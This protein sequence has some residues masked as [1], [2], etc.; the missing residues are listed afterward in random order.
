MI[1]KCLR[2]SMRILNPV[3]YKKAF[4]L[5]AGVVLILS[6]TGAAAAPDKTATA[7]TECL[8]FIKSKQYDNAI[9]VCT[10]VIETNPSSYQAFYAR[11][12]AYKQMRRYGVA[13]A[14]YTN[15]IKIDPLFADAYEARGNAYD[16]KGAHSLALADYSKAIELNPSSY[17]VFHNRGIAY[18]RDKQYYMASADYTKAI[19]LFRH[20]LTLNPPSTD[21][22]PA[23]QE[24]GRLIEEK[25]SLVK[26]MLWCL[27]EIAGGL[28]F[29]FSAFS[30]KNLNGARILMFLAGACIFAYGTIPFTG[31]SFPGYIRTVLGTCTIGILIILFFTG[32]LKD[33]SASYYI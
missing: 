26:D 15:A 7:G 11:G 33:K 21:T 4:S 19:R 2:N 9:T 30:K 8:A 17:R 27:I 6:Q 22:D 10:K 12:L 31:I 29:M 20:Q 23:L 18:W 24:L 32:E 16:D 1:L 14:D 3:K 25:N 5:L 28:F 13:I